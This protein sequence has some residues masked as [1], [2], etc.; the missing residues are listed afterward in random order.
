MEK[1]TVLSLSPSRHELKSREATLRN[2]GLRVI[3]VMSAVQARFEIE[4]GR[5][6]VFLVC[7][8]LSSEKAEELT[9]LFRRYCPE[10]KIIFVRKPD[11]KAEIP[12]EADFA[13]PESGGPELILK[14]LKETSASR[15]PDAA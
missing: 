7:Y 10:G 5:C 15:T 14:V 1:E 4:M 6:G 2:G 3:S 8:R 12:Q 13:V 9:H 11:Q